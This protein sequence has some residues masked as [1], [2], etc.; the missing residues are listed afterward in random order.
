MRHGA[1]LINHYV[2]F[3]LYAVLGRMAEADSLM[4]AHGNKIRQYAE[5]LR[6]TRPVRP[7][8]L[9]RGV[10]VDPTAVEDGFI[11]PDSQLTFISWSEDR[12]VACWFADTQSIISSFVKGRRPR[13]RGYIVIATESKAPTVLFH[14]SWASDFNLGDKSVQLAQLALLHPQLGRD[15]FVQIDW[16]LRTQHEVITENSDDPMPA[17]PVE[18]IGCPTTGEL[19]RR[20]APPWYGT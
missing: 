14:W 6:R 5:Y 3:V 7:Q 1:E 9:F 4:R 10:L 18:S 13:V 20:L 19:D 8:R 16:S 11:D 17:T 15:A 12:D 2:T